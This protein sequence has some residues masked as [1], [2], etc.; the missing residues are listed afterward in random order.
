MV[1]V[2]VPEIADSVVRFLSVYKVRAFGESLIPG[3]RPSEIRR[4]AADFWQVYA[5]RLSDRIH[6]IEYVTLSLER[7]K[8][9]CMSFSKFMIPSPK[10]LAVYEFGFETG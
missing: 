6:R 2:Y 7:Y 8:Q 5:V 10:H 9:V 1:L 3:Y 4:N